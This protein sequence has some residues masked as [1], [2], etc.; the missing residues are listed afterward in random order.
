[1]S[2]D[3]DLER[4]KI[5]ENIIANC[6]RDGAFPKIRVLDGY[7]NY[8]LID[9]DTGLKFEIKFDEMSKD[10]ENVCIEI[11][12]KEK[13]AGL[14]QS[15]ATY[16]VHIWI[17]EGKY[18]YNVIPVWELK[19]FIKL[20]REKITIRHD[21]GDGNSSVCLIPKAIFKHWRVHGIIPHKHLT[22]IK[23]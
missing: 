14:S 2:F 1:M 9:D 21:A 12:T 4:G 10:T 13:P 17:D 19:R 22:Q 23:K 5:W 20:H 15:L 3:D 7:N 11:G 8:D 18:V 16:W 6:M